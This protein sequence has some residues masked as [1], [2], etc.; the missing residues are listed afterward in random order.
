M[1]CIMT[2]SASIGALECGS[3]ALPTKS[4]LNACTQIYMTGGR[5]GNE[6]SNIAYSY[7]VG[8]CCLLCEQFSKTLIQVLQVP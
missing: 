3:A 7:Y 8:K 2:H 5:T 1:N 6:S 4:P